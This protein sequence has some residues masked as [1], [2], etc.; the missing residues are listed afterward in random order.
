MRS[1]NRLAGHSRPALRA[2]RGLW[3]L[4]PAEFDRLNAL[5]GRV[6]QME[7]KLVVPRPAGAALGVKLDRA[8]SRRVYFLDT[9]DLDLERHGVVVRVRSMARRGDSVIKLR[10]ALLGDLPDKL[11]RN[12]RV[13]VEVDAMPGAFVCSAT[14]KQRLGPQVVDRAISGRRPLSTLFT[15]DQQA[16]FAVCSPAGV[17][18]DDLLLYG[19]VEVRK[20]KAVPAGLG[21]PLSVEQWTYPDGARIL[22][23]STRC[24]MAD[25]VPVASRLAAT[26]RARRIEPSRHQPTKTRR[27]LAYFAGRTRS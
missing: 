24:A 19:P 4:S 3:R 7:L 15:K 9:A 2:A 27:T 13:T 22:E 17:R 23:I 11:R 26:L 18:L 12:K 1:A 25:S 6:A 21:R 16:L 5:T 20:A 14:L 8:G 10:P